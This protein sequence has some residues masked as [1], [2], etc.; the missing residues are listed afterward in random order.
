MNYA[1]AN[2]QLT[3]NPR[4]VLIG[5]GGTGGFVA[6][7]LC[8]LLTGSKAELVLIDHDIVEPHNLLRQNFTERDTGEFKSK[9]LAERLARE[10]NRPIG[11]SIYPYDEDL[12]RK[13]RASPGITIACV[14]N[15]ATRNLLHR[16]NSYGPSWYIDAGNGE[17]W[18]QILIGNTELSHQLR[19]DEALNG[20]LCRH[21]PLPGLQRPD[22]LEPEPP[23]LPRP[24]CA[25]ALDLTDQDPTINAT[26]AAL[27]VQTIRKMIQG[28]CHY[29]ALYL[30]LNQGT[31]TPQNITPKKL[32]HYAAKAQ[33]AEREREKNDA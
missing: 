14:D 28:T 1:I 26:M 13:F 31:V 4:F 17:T 10:F 29:M 15:S 2:Q 19:P 7:S 22:L 9:A 27:T 33:R 6:E 3:R 16:Q 18:G 24:D 5:C 25:A 8:R 30:D 11:Y 32:S 20:N 21:L 23:E 12:Q